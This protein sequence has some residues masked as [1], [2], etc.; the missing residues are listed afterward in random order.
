M[1]VLTISLKDDPEIVETYRRYH[2]EVWPEVQ[3]S[4]ERVGVER[5]DIHLLGRRLVMLVEMGWT[6]GRRSA[7]MPRRA[8]GSWNGND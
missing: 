2:R 3:A 4:L 7:R 5:M 6:I 1:T 8:R